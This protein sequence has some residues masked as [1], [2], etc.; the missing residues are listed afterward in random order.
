[1]G[2]CLPSHCKTGGS[3]LKG[4][5]LCTVMCIVQEEHEDKVFLYVRK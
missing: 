3:S 4:T 5:V 1:M 2:R